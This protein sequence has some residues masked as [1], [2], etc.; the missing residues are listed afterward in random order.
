MGAHSLAVSALCTAEPSARRVE[1]GGCDSLGAGG[2]KLMRL[3]PDAAK[4]LLE[5]FTG[6][7]GGLSAGSLV[8]VLHIGGPA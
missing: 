2:V 1:A 4:E 3:N 5:A 6:C 7:R 8:R